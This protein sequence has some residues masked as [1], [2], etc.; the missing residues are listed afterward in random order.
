MSCISVSLA[1]ASALVIPATASAEPVAPAQASAFQTSTNAYFK[2][3]VTLDYPAINALVTPDFHI[4]KDGKPVSSKIAQMVETAHLTMH[5]FDGGA[6]VDS[7]DMSGDTV[8]E[9]VTI[10][11]RGETMGNEEYE[12]TQQASVSKHVLTWVK[13]PSGKWLLSRDEIAYDPTFDSK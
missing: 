4:V 11:L 5:N 2:A 6:K 8:T 12:N 10:T 9:N 13:S 3:I 1:L 7:L